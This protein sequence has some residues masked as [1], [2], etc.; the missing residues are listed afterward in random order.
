MSEDL[1]RAPGG[2][3]AGSRIAGYLLEE[4][5][6]RGGM[7]VVFRAHDERLDRTV[8]LK[9]LAPALADDDAFRQRFIRESRAAA[10]VDDPH[11]IPV[12][13]AGEA[14][15][16]LF[17]AMRYVRGGDVGTL[18][19]QLGPLPQARMAAIVSQVASALDAAHSRNLVH[20]DVKPANMLLD[21]TSGAGRPDHVYLSDF[22]LS[23]TSLQVS[24]L[25]A[26]GQFLGTL[27][28]VAPEQIEAKPVDGR[29]DQYA[30]ACAAYELLAGVPPFQRE[31]AMAV[32]FAQLSDPPPRLAGR[33]PDLPGEVDAVLA[34]A[35]AKAPAN[36]YQTCTDFTEALRSACGLRPYDTGPDAAPRAAHP[37]TM[38]AQPQTPQ[39]PRQG[40]Q[41]AAVAQERTPQPMPQ[42]AVAVTP[43]GSE[44]TIPREPSGAT[45]GGSGGSSPRASTAP[46]PAAIPAGGTVVAPP[47]GPAYTERLTA[48]G[49]AAS[50]P[51]RRTALLAGA[52]TIVL[53]AATVVAIEL[54]SGHSSPGHTG[55]GHST[56]TGIASACLPP[57]TGGTVNPATYTQGP[58][59]ADT[60]GGQSVVEGAA[61]SPDGSELAVGDHDGTTDVWST[62]TF[63]APTALADP[64]GNGVQAVAFSCN[65][66]SVAIADTGGDTL[67]WPITGTSPSATFADPAGP[68]SVMAV[69]FSPNGKLL[70]TGDENGDAYLWNIKT[71]SYRKIGNPGN[72][73]NSVQA[74]AFSPDGTT[75]AT[76]DS[77]GSVYLWSTITGRRVNAYQDSNS[78]GNGIQAVAFSPDGGTLAA[79]DS[80]GSTYL[81]NLSTPSFVTLPDPSPGTLGVVAL[82]FGPDGRTL[83]AGDSN[84][85]TYLWNVSD[86]KLARTLPG[87]GAGVG[88]QAVAF[89]P[90]GDL[91][92]E[93]FTNGQSY[94]WQS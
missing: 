19:R 72:P 91:L 33:R 76:G 39:R 52:A 44:P 31:S 34:K 69:A 75:L 26:T 65:G 61:F 84:G 11:I 48:A 62:A 1:P 71:H 22:G 12:F 77:D 54:T 36:R 43:A 42:P 47:A 27:E 57:A 10:A 82:A 67:L 85:N 73:G 56:T 79:G 29:A 30:L 81:W 58:T 2:F 89:S 55:P 78:G 5:I 7:A 4:Q 37:A 46:I 94:I 9:I 64:G 50:P 68:V 14:S 21:A 3:A 53:V 32:M 23:K 80:N 70:A 18:V 92:A 25:T 86:Q 93:G 88:V 20:R 16:V 66:K 38:V 87:P 90:N 17:I 74:V 45:A 59:L 35:L 13:E 15:G 41:A 51:R 83:A 8:A 60:G 49:P 40:I 24:G 63:T 6:G 28:Y